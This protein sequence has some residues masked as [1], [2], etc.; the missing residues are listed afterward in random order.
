MCCD[1]STLRRPLFRLLHF[2][3]NRAELFQ[4]S[5]VA[6]THTGMILPIVRS[7]EQAALK[8]PTP[9]QP[10]HMDPDP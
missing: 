9:V 1:C 8:P 4:F 5:E 10:I 6:D 7:K 3:T 2:E